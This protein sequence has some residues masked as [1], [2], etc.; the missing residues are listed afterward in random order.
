MPR[1][2]ILAI[3]GTL[4]SP[5]ANYHPL[6]AGGGWRRTPR[7]ARPGGRS[8]RPEHVLH[9]MLELFKRRKPRP[10]K[11]PSSS[12]NACSGA[13]LSCLP[14]AISPARRSWS[15]PSSKTLRCWPPWSVRWMHR[16]STTP[17][18]K[19]WHARL[20][21]VALPALRPFAQMY[22]MHPQA[23][24]RQLNRAAQLQAQREAAQ[25]EADASAATPQ[26]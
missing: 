5:H 19:P 13:L 2:E 22:G 17:A 10:V 25:T 8:N 18:P 11:R 26:A 23:V 4:T 3:N 9:A 21:P 7:P 15:V 12:K 20:P 24:Q 16:P 6:P 14:T 1:D